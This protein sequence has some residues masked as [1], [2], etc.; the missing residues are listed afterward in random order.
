MRNYFAHACFDIR[1]ICVF[2]QQ[3]CNLPNVN[4]SDGSMHCYKGPYALC[5]K[6]ELLNGIP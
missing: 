4:E 1:E 2:A 5:H 6:D 3:L